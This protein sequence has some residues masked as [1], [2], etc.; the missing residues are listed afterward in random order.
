MTAPDT[1]A[2]ILDEMY[3]D[4][5]EPT[6]TE[7]PD[8]EPSAPSLNEVHAEPAA[9]AH[10]RDEQGRFAPKPKADADTATPVATDAPATPAP[11]TETVDPWTTA[12][13][14]TYR[15][16]GE[17]RTLDG[18]VV[19]DGHGARFSPEAL[20]RVQELLSRGELYEK[21][22]HQ[23]AAERRAIEQERARPSV[24]ELQYEHAAT[25]LLGALTNE[26]ELGRLLDPEYR[27][28]FV[29]KLALAVEKAEIE[30]QRQTATQHQQ[31]QT[32]TQAAEAESASIQTVVQQMAQQVGGLT[33]K[34]VEQANAYFQSLRAALVKTAPDDRYLAQYGIA[35]GEKYLDH[36]P[37]QQY[38]TAIA[39]E[40]QQAAD[41]AKKAQEAAR[42]NQAQQ[43]KPVVPPKAKASSTAQPAA[44]APRKSGRDAFEDVFK[45][46]KKSPDL[47]FG[48]DDE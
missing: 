36:G 44:P 30:H 6:N 31:V 10:P 15:V 16:A 34:D 24:K 18:A 4:V 40:R 41:A 23:I 19:A 43:P 27:T 11:T 2:G 7:A 32:E 17:T 33:D 12:Q 28:L 1:F 13:P 3:T 37:I 20:P 35:A 39:R 38:L 25:T 46:W 8:A 29:Q 42:F 9:E 45:Q 26:E 22:R 48:D 21:E 14:F 47:S 5:E